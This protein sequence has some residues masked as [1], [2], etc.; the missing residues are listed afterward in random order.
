MSILLPLSPVSF[1]LP[2]FYYSPDYT[3]DYS[4][5]LTQVVGFFFLAS[6][7]EGS[8]RKY[9]S[10]SLISV[11][12]G[13]YTLFYMLIFS[14][15]SAVSFSSL[16][17]VQLSLPR[18][19]DTRVQ[20]RMHGVRVAY[21]MPGPARYTRGLHAHSDTRWTAYTADEIKLSWTLYVLR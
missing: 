19:A 18:L 2:V 16:L 21:Y 13:L 4:V 1:H 9:P 17:C 3:S 7:S 11:A 14:R 15:S 8:T 12:F 5:T 20:S 6:L 10:P